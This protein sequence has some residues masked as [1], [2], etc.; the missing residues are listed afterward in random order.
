MK[1]TI[2]LLVIFLYYSMGATA[3]A[4]TSAKKKAQDQ[5]YSQV[6]KILNSDKYYGYR[7]KNFLLIKNIEENITGKILASALNKWKT[8]LIARKDD[9]NADKIDITFEMLKLHNKN[10]LLK[11][12][13][14][15]DR[16]DLLDK[17]ALINEIIPR[18]KK[19]D[20]QEFLYPLVNTRYAVQDEHDL[21]IHWLEYFLQNPNV[22]VNCYDSI[23]LMMVAIEN[24]NIDVPPILFKH[25]YVVTEGD[26]EVLRDQYVEVNE[27]NNDVII[28]EKAL[29]ALYKIETLLMENYKK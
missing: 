18:M 29:E 2:C 20:S 16:E 5:L 21:A 25:G 13:P 1:G 7:V 12:F 28:K 10:K 3:M 19:I 4:E 26:F 11:V 22:D 27:D 15:L 17:L 8:A 23:S 14:N 24:F 9:I 6:A